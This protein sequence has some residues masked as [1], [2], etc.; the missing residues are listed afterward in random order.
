[1]EKLTALQAEIEIHRICESYWSYIQEIWPTIG[2]M[3]RILVS[4]R[5]SRVAGY[6]W[7]SKV[8]SRVEYNLTFAITAGIDTF[9][10][11][12]VHELAH[13]VCFRLYPQAAQAHGPEFRYIM[14]KLGYSGDT[15]HTMN[16]RVAKAA[17]T[18]AKSS[19]LSI[20][21]IL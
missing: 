12:V 3:P 6:A 11:T 5:K 1:M 20:A 10:E 2:A 14:G 13:I 21:G 7:K 8:D 18:E 15:Y 4:T 16:T 19:S 9:T 17:S